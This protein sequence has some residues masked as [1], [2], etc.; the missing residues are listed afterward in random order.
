MAMVRKGQVAA[1][2]A[3]DMT[4]QAT[5]NA[6]LFGMAAYATIKGFV[7]KWTLRQCQASSFNITRDIRG[8][9]HLVERAFNVSLGVLAEV[10][11]VITQ[12]FELQATWHRQ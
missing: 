9:A 2:P 11:Q 8:E 3:N 12:Q 6:K 5:F 7:V 10:V 4:V 1:I